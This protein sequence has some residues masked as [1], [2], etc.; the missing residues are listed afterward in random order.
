MISSLNSQQPLPFIGG[1]VL[2]YVYNI[3]PNY[4][5]RIPSK[6]AIFHGVGISD[7]HFEFGFT[8]T[9][10][11]LVFGMINQRLTISTTG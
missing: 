8:G 5:V 1:Y 7:L 11:I 10:P 9:L 3:H 4:F 2:Y 6:E